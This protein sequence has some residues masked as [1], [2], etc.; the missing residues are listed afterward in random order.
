M[1]S[2]QEDIYD[3]P[4][5]ENGNIIFTTISSTTTSGISS[6]DDQ[7]SVT[8][9]LPNA[10][11]GDVMNVECLQL[12][13][14]SGS[15]SATMQLLPLAGTQKTATV[16]ADKKATV[17]Y[18]RTEAKLVKLGDYVTVVFNGETDYAKQ[19]IELIAATT[20]TKPKAG[21]KEVDI[22]RTDETAYFNVTVKPKL[23][24]YTGTLVVTRKNGVKDT[25]VVVPGSP[26]A[27]ADPFLV[28][29]S[30][31]DFAAGKDTMIYSFKATSGTYSDDISYTVV[32]RD[33]Y[34]YLKKTGITLTLGGSSAGR[35]I[36]TNKGVAATD[37]NAILA[38]DGGSLIIHGGSNWAVSGKEISFVPA[39]LALYDK[40][41]SLDAIA[42]FTAGTPTSTA[43]PIVGAGVYIFKIV[44]GPNPSDVYY[45]MIRVVSVVPGVSITLEYRIGNQYAH[46]TVI[47]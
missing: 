23:S 1:V 6:L 9:T 24:T 11:Q 31:T 16:G 27:T 2:C 10:K 28:P 39:T 33:P 14:P 5:D 25:P 4:R 36:L 38:I 43:D 3:V 29:I 15:A 17:T 37:A 7:F 26:F 30:G 35:N 21:G 47:S 45:G 32:V 18:T 13:V 8:A 40:N 12:Q 42:A 19:R 34:F 20:V 46:L 44:N 22:T 41:S